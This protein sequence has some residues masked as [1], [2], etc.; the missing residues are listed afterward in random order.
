MTRFQHSINIYIKLLISLATKLTDE[1]RSLK[2]RN[3]KKR[4]KNLIFFHQIIKYCIFEEL[5]N[6]T[7]TSKE[8]K[9]SIWNEENTKRCWP[10]QAR[11][12]SLVTFRLPIINISIASIHSIEEV[13]EVAL[14]MYLKS[15]IDERSLFPKMHWQRHKWDMIRTIIIIRN[16]KKYLLNRSTHQVSTFLFLF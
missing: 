16:Q 11:V 13:I 7:S 9:F 1:A 8:E 3:N 6:K 12:H 15:V 2:R 4:V 5:K 14:K 10:Y